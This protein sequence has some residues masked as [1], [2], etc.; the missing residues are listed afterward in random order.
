MCFQYT[1]GKL[2]F[3]TVRY[4]FQEDESAVYDK[5]STQ[6][7]C[8]DGNILLSAQSHVLKLVE[9][10]VVNEVLLQEKKDAV[11]FM[12]LQLGE[13]FRPENCYKQKNLRT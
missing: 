11:H 5:C 2:L 13:I 9:R 7:G 12:M 1:D 3:M 8:R 10:N 6:T 4:F